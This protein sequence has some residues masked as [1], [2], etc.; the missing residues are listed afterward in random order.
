MEKE[1]DH[2]QPGFARLPMGCV[3]SIFK[4]ESN[5]EVTTSRSRILADPKG[6]ANEGAAAIA[7]VC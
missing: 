2:R 7:S 5:A 3:A 6:P 1:Q 4:G